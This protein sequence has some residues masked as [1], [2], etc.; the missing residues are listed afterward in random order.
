MDQKINKFIEKIISTTQSRKLLWKKKKEEMIWDNE[1]SS[2]FL[3]K[4]AYTAEYKDGTIILIN[5]SDKKALP[6][7]KGELDYYI[8]AVQKDERSE[9]MELNSKDEL[10]PDLFRLYNI[11]NRQVLQVDEFID[12]FLDEN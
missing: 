3:E 2:L 11:I 7:N 1:K 8:L 5:Y 9:V 6:F 12:S 4:R 10:Q